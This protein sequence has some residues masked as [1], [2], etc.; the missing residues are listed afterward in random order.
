MTG[1]GF[2]VVP[3]VK[4]IVRGSFAVRGTGS[5]GRAFFSA[6]ANEIHPGLS[7]PM[8][9]KCS[10]GHLPRASSTSPIA[11]TWAITV[12]APAVSAR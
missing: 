5:A 8:R 4:L 6:F 10:S 3:E 12:R 2:P 7:P 1:F 11:D 9:M